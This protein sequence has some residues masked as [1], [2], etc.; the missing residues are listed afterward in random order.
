MQNMVESFKGDIDRVESSP[1]GLRASLENTKGFR[2]SI[3]KSFRDSTLSLNTVHKT[4]DRDN[5]SVR[6]FY[7][8]DDSSFI[9]ASN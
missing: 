9:M 1:K 5:S 2:A 7:V 6:Y 4:L 8:K 3:R